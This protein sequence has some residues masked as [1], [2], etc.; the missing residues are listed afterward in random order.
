M[1][2]AR[3]TECRRRE[4]GQRDKEQA[5]ESHLRR[6]DE[7]PQG[8]QSVC[9]KR[10]QKNIAWVGQNNLVQAQK[11]IEFEQWLAQTGRCSLAAHQAP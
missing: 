9:H 6:R 4:A 1:K 7:K 10:N 3:Q 5:S 11:Q 2:F 8:H